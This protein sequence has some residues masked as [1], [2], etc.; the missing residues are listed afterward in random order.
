MKN[1]GRAKQTTLSLIE[2]IFG[3]SSIR[4]FAIKLW[5]GTVWNPEPAEPAA[6]TMILKHAGALRSMFLPPTELN[7]A[8]SYVYNDYDVVGDMETFI[9]F[10]F[11]F[12]DASWGKMARLRYGTRL[13]SLPNTNSPH[14]DEA[15]VKLRGERHSRERVRQAIEYHYSRSNDF[16]ALFLDPHMLYSC[17]YFLTPDEDLETAQERKLDY[18]CRKLRLQPGQRLTSRTIY[19]FK[20]E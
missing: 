6:F 8:E 4:N 3:S 12:L 11:Q 9:R 10:A 17:A 14:L 2:D 15:G 5:D 19:R 20:T 18:I 13:L 16:F 7:M 1:A